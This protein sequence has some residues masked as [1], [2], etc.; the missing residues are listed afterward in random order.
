VPGGP[1]MNG[2]NCFLHFWNGFW[3]FIEEWAVG[4]IENNPYDD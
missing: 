2:L 4:T 3:R 1:V